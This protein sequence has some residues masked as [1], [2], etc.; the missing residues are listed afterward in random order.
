M[1]FF[2]WEYFNNS[3]LII[4][5][6][7]HLINTNKKIGARQLTINV[8]PNKVANNFFELNHLQG[9]CRSS[10]SIGLFDNKGQLLSAASFG[11]SRYNK[12]YNH[13]LLRF[14]SLR[15]TAV[16]GA[17]GRLLKYYIQNHVK[18]NE[19]IVSY[20]N[21]RWSTGNLYKTLGFKL[22]HISK[23]G[24]YYI[25]KSGKYVGNRQLW[26]KHMLSKKLLTFDPNLTEWE[27][28]Q[29]NGYTRV[30]DCGNLVYTMTIT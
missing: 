11:N 16:V 24:Y 6:I 15:G 26:Q 21:R 19:S 12:R 28:M 4:D 8:V 27:N 9:P 30:W 25:T 14:A 22:D 23:P 29:A 5:K 1:Q 10:I 18:S 7:S 2:D 20:C 13:E 17:A 3:D